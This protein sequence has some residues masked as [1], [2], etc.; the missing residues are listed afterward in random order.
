MQHAR[1]TVI[2]NST[3]WSKRL[4]THGLLVSVW[5]MAVLASIGILMKY[6]EHHGTMRKMRNAP[7]YVESYGV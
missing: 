5:H 2:A 6:Q 1:Q 3:K 7:E 4:Y